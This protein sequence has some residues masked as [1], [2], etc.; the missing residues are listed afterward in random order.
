M[1]LAW[2][3]G[4]ALASL[5]GMGSGDQPED[6]VAAAKAVKKFAKD[7]E[8]L[9]ILGGAMGEEG[10]GDLLTGGQP[11]VGDRNPVSNRGSAESLPFD[12]LGEEVV[13]GEFG[14]ARVDQARHLLQRLLPA[15]RG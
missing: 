9:T 1:R 11:A 12:Q 2:S 14:H 15:R 5:L 6:P 8:K 13:R 10:A 7:N 3:F 4:L